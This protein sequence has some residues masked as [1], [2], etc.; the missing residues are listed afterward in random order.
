MPPPPAC[1]ARGGEVDPKISP[2]T[3][4]ECGGKGARGIHAHPGKR[5][6]KSNVERQPARP[7]RAGELR[8]AGTVRNAQ[9]HRHQQR[10]NHELGDEGPYRPKGARKSGDVADRRCG[11]CI[12]QQRGDDQHAQDATDQLREDVKYRIPACDLPQSPKGQRDRRIHVRTGTFAPRR[13]NEPD[14]GQSHGDTHQRAPQVLIRDNS[15]QWRAGKAQE[16]R[17]NSRP[18]S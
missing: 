4:R 1:R 2:Q 10:R 9:D 16:R 6:L 12:A 8:I 18:R 3:G 13:I 11:K 17:K 5:R 14:G 7:R 15:L